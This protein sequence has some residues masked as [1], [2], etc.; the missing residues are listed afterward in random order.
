[1]WR[2]TKNCA[3]LLL[4]S[5]EAP[6]KEGAA[7]DFRIAHELA[8]RLRL[9]YG[10]VSSRE[11]ARIHGVDIAYESW[12][13][14]DG[15]IIYF[16]ECSI[17]P[18]RI[19]VNVGAIEL[20]ARMAFNRF[21]ENERRWFTQTAIAEVVIAHELYHILTRQTSDLTVESLAHEF[22]RR[23]TGAPFSP[24]QYEVI[25]RQSNNELSS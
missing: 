22:A 4:V 7:A 11:L 10:C 3:S 6:A 25:L 18:P 9:A 5:N 24:A 12:Q 14:A 19:I 1:M 23:I 8:D 13:V 17:S 15:R 16:G 2:S 21:P 20:L